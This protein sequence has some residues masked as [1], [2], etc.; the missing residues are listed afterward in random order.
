MKTVDALKTADQQNLSKL[1]QLVF[2]FGVVPNFLSGVGLP[3]ERRNKFYR[4]ILECNAADGNNDGAMKQKCDEKKHHRLVYVAECLLSILNHEV[5][6]SIILKNHIGDVLAVL[7]QLAYGPTHKGYTIKVY[8]HNIP[9]QFYVLS[10]LF[11]L[12]FVLIN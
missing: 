10:L 11:C 12:Y 7:I 9:V 3:I 2:L 8:I 1:L 5:F 4:C 6:A